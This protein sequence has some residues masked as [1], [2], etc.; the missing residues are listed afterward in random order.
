MTITAVRDELASRLGAIGGLRVYPYPPDSVSE[1]PAAIIQPGEPLVEYDRTMGGSDA[2]YRFSALL[3]AQSA[4]EA[5]AWK[6]LET[7]LN[8]SGAGSIKA[9][10][11]EETTVRAGGADWFRVVRA[12]GA[13]RV[14]YNRVA[15]WGVTFLIQSYS[16]G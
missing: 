15:Y 8:P 9:A 6:E 10:V 11:E 16:G 7:Y 4:D 1:L 14:T 2:S 12:T 5:Q 3:L 13:G